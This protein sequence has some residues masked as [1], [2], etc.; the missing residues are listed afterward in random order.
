MSKT[1]S[2]KNWNTLNRQTHRSRLLNLMYFFQ[3]SQVT[4]HNHIHKKTPHSHYHQNLEDLFAETTPMPKPANHTIQPVT[5]TTTEAYSGWSP[6]SR[7]QNCI[8]RR[9]KICTSETC[10]DSR[11]YEE[12]PCNKKR[13]KRKNRN[14]EKFHVVHLNK[15]SFLFF[16]VCLF[17]TFP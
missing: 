4:L 1:R 11:I 7:C 2:D 17:L 14:R 13:C 10:G 16:I 15:V 3:E 8:Q 12:R 6:W 5:V 9:M